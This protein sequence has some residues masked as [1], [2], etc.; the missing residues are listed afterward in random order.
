MF[1]AGRVRKAKDTLYTQPVTLC[2][3]RRIYRWLSGKPIF[4]LSAK[5]LVQE[6]YE[7]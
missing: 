7:V 3:E 4:I 6:I 5:A 2:Y 1:G